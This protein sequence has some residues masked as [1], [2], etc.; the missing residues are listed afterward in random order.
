MFG[1]KVYSFLDQPEPDPEL[2][3]IYHSFTH[4]T[5]EYRGKLA[6]AL[7]EAQMEMEQKSVD[8]NSEEAKFILSEVFKKWRFEDSS[9][10]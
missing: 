3:R 1:M 6:Q 4:I 10:K 7:W 9:N 8:A 2:L 5:G